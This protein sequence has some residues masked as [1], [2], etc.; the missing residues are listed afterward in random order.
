MSFITGAFV[1]EVRD[2]AHGEDIEEIF[3]E[4]Q[5]KYKLN[6]LKWGEIK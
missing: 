1:M 6:V 2:E 5:E 3:S 4:I